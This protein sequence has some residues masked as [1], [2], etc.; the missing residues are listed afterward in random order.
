MNFTGQ[1]RC[2]LNKNSNLEWVGFIVSTTN[3]Y[4]N[5][6]NGIK[7][8]INDSLPYCELTKVENDK[9]VFG[10]ISDKEDGSFSHKYLSGVFGS[11][12]PKK[13]K[14]E[15][16]IHINSVGEGSIWV[17]NINGELENGDYISSSNI[18]GYGQ[19][20]TLH[21]DFLTR[22]TVAKITC[23]CDFNLI[24]IPRQ[25][26]QTQTISNENFIVYDTNGDIQ[27]ID[28]LDGS[29]NQIFE[30]KYNTRF[31][32]AS[33]NILS[34]EDEYNN[35]KLNSENVYIACFVGCSYHCG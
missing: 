34:G 26:L 28:D 14:N 19:K 8:T 3:K 20:Q 31:L 29:G 9:R 32:D 24:K 17:C 23:D 1:H 30:Y 13:N 18:L 35:K 16:R 10:V 11:F 25:K 22:F 15:Q 21:E 6:D 27:F 33:A 7:P 2:L 4:I 12:I 5:L